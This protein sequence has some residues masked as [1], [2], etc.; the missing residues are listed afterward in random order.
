MSSAAVYYNG[1]LAGR[2]TKESSRYVFVYD[3]AYIAAAGSRPVSLTLPLRTEPYK[4]DV[5]FPAFINLLS[6]GANKALQDRLL[7]IDEN[8]YFGLL[9]ATGD[10]D[11]IGPLSIKEETDSH[12][13]T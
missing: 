3:A 12:A 10:G 1:R 6:E 5:L 8:D 4:S 11:R 2:L 9:L 7:K 13:T